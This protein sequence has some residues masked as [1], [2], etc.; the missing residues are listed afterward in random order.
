MLIIDGIRYKE[1]DARRLGLLKTT[2]GDT[3]RPAHKAVQ[4]PAAGSG[5]NGKSRPKTKRAAASSE[6]SADGDAPAAG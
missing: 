1:A 6:G 4:A 5:A 3:P 2:E